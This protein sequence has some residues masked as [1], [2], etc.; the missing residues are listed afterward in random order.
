M[1]L[2]MVTLTGHYETAGATPISGT[3]T[4]TPSTAL[5]SSSNSMI[6]QT[7]TVTATLDGT[8]AFSVT[9]LATDASGVAPTGWTYQ[10]VEQFTGGIGRTYSIQLPQANSPVDL[11][12]I[13]P[14][15]PAGNVSTYGSLAGNNTWTGTNTFNGT[16]A[17]ISPL[18]L[19]QGGLGATTAAGGRTNLGL[20]TAATAPIDQTAGD[21]AP[22][23]TQGAGTTGKVADAGHIHAMPR[24][25]QINAPTTAVGLNSQKITSLANGTAST[26]A[27][28]F[29]QIPTA[30]PPNGTAGGDLSGTYPNPTVAKINGIAVTGTPTTGQVPTATSGTAATWQTPSGGGGTPSGSAGGD[31]GSTYPNP[32]VT[33]THLSAPLPIAQGGTASATRT[34][35]SLITPTT[36]KT[37]AYTAAPGDYVIVDASSASV[38]ITLPAAPANL[39]VIGIKMINA[40]AP[41]TTT[42][43]ASGSDVFNKTGGSTTL[44]L[45]LLNQSTAIQYV[46]GIWYV[47][48]DDLSL[49]QLDARYATPTQIPS[50]DSYHYADNNLLWATDNPRL[51]SASP[52]PTNGTC[53]GKLLLTR[54]LL[55]RSTTLTNINFGLAGVDTTGPISNSYIGIYDSTGTLRASTADIS[56]TLM[57]TATPKT[58]A[59]ATPYTAAPGEYFIAMLLNGT[60]TSA[61][62]LK[63][64]GGGVTSNIGLTAPHLALSNYGTSQTTLPSTIT[65]ASQAT[66]LIT[67]GVGSTWYGIS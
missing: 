41:N 7:E 25:D 47:Y 30:L 18:P 58:I 16:V 62:T 35:A 29:G 37:S 22:L 24:L 56:S 42:V 2:P 6:I 38:A 50:D 53:A 46:G 55:R 31:L 40:T 45:T 13:S 10:V 11:S 48:S 66:N 20:G 60:W 44:T 51:A 49:A 12:A 65:L 5:Q 57:G 26:D 54:M 9:L 43:T 17:L 61:F 19:A 27:A 33:A 34:W 23:G 36:V 59:F 28:A 52:N 64:T 21:I 67:G 1:T 15:A 39:T 8:G 63:S 4:F 3:V 14:V 32:T